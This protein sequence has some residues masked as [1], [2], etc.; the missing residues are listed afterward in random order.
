MVTPFDT[1]AGAGRAKRSATPVEPS[2]GG[3]K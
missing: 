1:P 3:G 2:G